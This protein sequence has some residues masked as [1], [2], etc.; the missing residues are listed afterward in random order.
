MN[1]HREQKN[2]IPEAILAKPPGAELAIDE[3]TGKPLVA[4]DAHMPYPF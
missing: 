1:K 3:A 4:E 2:S